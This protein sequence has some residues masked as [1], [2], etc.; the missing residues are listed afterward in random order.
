MVRKAEKN[1]NIKV[2]VLTGREDGGRKPRIRDIFLKKECKTK[3][4]SM[5]GT[6][7]YFY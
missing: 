2:V 5:L 4:V 3:L 6:S 1:I 7:T